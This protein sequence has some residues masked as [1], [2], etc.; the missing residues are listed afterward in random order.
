MGL[1]ACTYFLPAAVFFFLAHR[2]GAQQRCGLQIDWKIRWSRLGD[3]GLGWIRI[4]DNNRLT[5]AY[6]IYVYICIYIYI[7]VR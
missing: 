4:E 6:T 7:Y 3:I 1:Y 5:I 2:D